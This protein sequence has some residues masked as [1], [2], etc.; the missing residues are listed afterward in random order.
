M[1]YYVFVKGFGLFTDMYTYNCR[2]DVLRTNKKYDLVVSFCLYGRLC[3]DEILWCMHS[4]YNVASAWLEE[5]NAVCALWTVIWS[6]S[7]GFDVLVCRG[8]RYL[9]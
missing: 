7:F 8:Q 9:G 5:C 1:V 3:I 6:H 2:L 4:R